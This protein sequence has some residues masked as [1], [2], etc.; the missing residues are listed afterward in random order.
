MGIIRLYL[1][2]LQDITIANNRGP[3]WG[4][5]LDLSGSN[6]LKPMS[7]IRVVNNSASGIRIVSCSPWYNNQS[8][9]LDDVSVTNNRVTAEVCGWG[10]G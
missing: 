5:A 1:G 7:G 3:A 4:F 2:V 9:M 8:V 10:C 6:L